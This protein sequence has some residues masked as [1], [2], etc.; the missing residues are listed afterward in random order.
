MPFAS[1]LGSTSSSI[2]LPASI[3]GL[4]ITMS[5]ASLALSCT[6]CN[7]ARTFLRPALLLRKVLNFSS[8]IDLGARPS[9]A[10]TA[11]SAVDSS[12]RSAASA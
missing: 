11:A 10:E 8:G 6:S 2:I 5:A 7:K 9:A 12:M 1:I 4:W 3:Q